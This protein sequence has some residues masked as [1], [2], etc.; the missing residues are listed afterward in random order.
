[1]FPKGFEVDGL[2]ALRLIDIIEFYVDDG[3][4]ISVTELIRKGK[5]FAANALVGL[6][7]FYTVQR[8]VQQH[9]EQP[10][11]GVAFIFGQFIPE[12][13]AVFLFLFINIRRFDGQYPISLSHAFIV[14]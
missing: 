4:S 5:L 14:A 11:I 2:A 3:E 7:K 13:N 1:M 6:F 10:K 9:F 12:R 8:I